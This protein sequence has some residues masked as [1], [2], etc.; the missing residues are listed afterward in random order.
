M[1]LN[2]TDE[3]FN[4]SQHCVRERGNYHDDGTLLS[5]RFFSKARAQSTG[6]NLPPRIASCLPAYCWIFG[7]GSGTLTSFSPS[8]SKGRGLKAP[9]PIAHS[10]TLVF[11]TNEEVILVFTECPKRFVFRQMSVSNVSTSIGSTVGDNSSP[12]K[13]VKP[14]ISRI[15]F[16][17]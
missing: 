17:G 2:E 16:S 3:A 7:Y 10:T 14:G 11:I 4:S 5:V 12:V 13:F 1:S 9:P 6:L 15:R 8:T